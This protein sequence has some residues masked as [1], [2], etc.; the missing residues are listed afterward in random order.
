[1]ASIAADF[2]NEGHVARIVAR[3][4]SPEWI[5]YWHEIKMDCVSLSELGVSRDALDSEI[6]D[7]CQRLEIVLI[8]IN[9]NDDGPYSL[10]ATIRAKNDLTCLPVLTLRNSD[11]VLT[12]GH[13]LDDVVES[14]FDKLLTLDERRGAGRLFLP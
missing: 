1:M 10:E 6:W 13:Y 9:R 14:L 7:F 2:N 4:Q 5:E 3:M 12:S 8:T 11:R